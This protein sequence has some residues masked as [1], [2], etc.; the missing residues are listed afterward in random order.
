LEQLLSSKTFQ[1]SAK[2]AQLLRRLVEPTLSGTN[3]PVKE[4][5]LGI[6]VF[7]RPSDWDP[8]TDSIVRVHV[9]RL[10][11][12]LKSY[13]SD[14]DPPST[15]RFV[16]PKGSYVA[17]CV[18]TSPEGLPN[19]QTQ[20]SSNKFEQ[21]HEAHHVRFF[22]HTRPPRL[23]DM[24]LERLTYERGDLTNAVF[25]PDGESV[26][27]SA[28]WRGEP[29]RIYWHRI[30]Q[31]HSRALGLPP[32]ELRDVSSDGQLLFTLGEGPIGTLAQAE[33]SGG[34]LREIVD[35]VLDAVWLPDSRHIAAARLEGGAM[36]IELPLGNPVHTLTGKQSRIR[37]SV[38]PTGERVAFV[39][40]S[41]GP[42]DICLAEANGNVRRI[43]EEWRVIGGIRWLSSNYL[44]VSG[45]RRGV[46][47]IHALDMQGNER[48]FYP[49]PDPWGL[50]DCSRDGRILASSMNTRLHI[51]F[52]TPSMQAEQTIFSVTNTRVIGLT[53]DA[54]FAVL[55]DLLT[56]GVS[57]NSPILLMALPDGQPIQIAEGYHPQV[58]PD[59]KSVICLER[60]ESETNILLTPIPSGLPR[61]YRLEPGRRYHSVEFLGTADRY[62]IHLADDA[63][64]LHS[65]IID[66]R[67]DKLS[68]VADEGYVTLIAPNGSCGVIPGGSELRL[69]SLES[70]TVQNICSLA[71]GWVP[72]RWSVRGNEI[73]VFEPGKDYA[74]GSILRV[75][76]N[77][78]EQ[79]EWLVLHPSDSAGA[80]FLP[81]LDITPD[82][83]SYAY[84]Y[85]QD[86]CD[87]YLIDG[88]VPAAD[89][90]L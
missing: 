58:A 26:V 81:W 34:P 70:G 5:I 36:R 89:V 33:L 60:R 67:T 51:G 2:L 62:L 23:G 8:Q 56:D 31:K 32:G 3:D 88:L 75:N 48:S 90:G 86:L 76:V 27:Y 83:R 52:R 30:G 7:E 41:L 24:R 59:G 35:G 74:L 64:A 13:Y 73:F 68:A 38:D 71:N 15:V 79:T 19:A 55:M 57:R 17:Q 80:Y 42:L 45:A 44:L 50:H 10:R 65:H 21:K 14:Q 20:E 16:I 63:G 22:L 47:A 6:E 69:A 39:T 1:R 37:L 82:G 4:Q 66:P 53:P 43:S 9:N 84:T 18:L 40:N 28:R 29:A 46:P 54:R 12:M 77:T 11:L 49:T 61:R 72:I 78:G 85:Q 87:L 25:C